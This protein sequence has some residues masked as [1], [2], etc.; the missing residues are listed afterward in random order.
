MLATQIFVVRHGQ[1][2][3]NFERRLQGQTDV[4]LDSLGRAQ[5]LAL[6]PALGSLHAQRPFDMAISSDL[7][8]AHA[9]ALPA[10]T[11]LGIAV[12][13][14]PVWRERHFGVLE[15][16]S[17]DEQQAQ[18][19]PAFE[20]WKSRDPLFALPKGESL[21]VF[22]NRVAGA[23]GPLIEQNAGKRILIVTHGGAIDMIYRYA[24]QMALQTERHFDITNA[25]IGM[26]ESLNGKLSIPLWAQTDHL[27]AISSP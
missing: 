11:A 12:A 8:R 1:T 14:D 4:E 23:M 17:P 9:T 18:Q 22:F 3:W 7:K 10:C 24:S 13:T 5:A 27:D 16:L 26:I 2:A 25:S 20:G 6:V 15:G 19:A 21:Q